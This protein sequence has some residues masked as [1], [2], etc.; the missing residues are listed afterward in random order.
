VG[1]VVVRRSSALPGIVIF[2]GAVLAL[3]LALAV[4]IVSSFPTHLSQLHAPHLRYL[5]SLTSVLDSSSSFRIAAVFE[6]HGISEPKVLTYQGNDLEVIGLDGR[7]DRLVPTDGACGGYY[8]V[9]A[10]VSP[11]GLWAVCVFVPSPSTPPTLFYL[12]LVSLRPHGPPV[13][14][15][16]ELGEEPILSPVWSPNGRYVALGWEITRIC[17][18]CSQ[19]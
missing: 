7:G 11:D 4:L 10:A 1:G 16:F 3:F 12:D 17:G 13:H 15:A 9:D 2:I 6:Q 5:S 18:Q 19:P 14:H 8:P